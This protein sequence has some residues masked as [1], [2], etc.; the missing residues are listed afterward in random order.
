[1]YKGAEAPGDV[2]MKDIQ[3]GVA[4][5]D[6]TGAEYI[7]VKARNDKKYRSIVADNLPIIAQRDGLA[8]H[9]SLGAF[10]SDWKEYRV[11]HI[12]SGVAVVPKHFDYKAEAIRLMESA[13]GLYVDW[14]AD[15]DS[16]RAATKGKGIAG[17]LDALCREVARR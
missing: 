7:K 17:K 4:M 9:L 16:I 13:C 6:L 12:V 11:S 3:A 2:M 15:Y 14:K 1:M 5:M 8:V 10:G